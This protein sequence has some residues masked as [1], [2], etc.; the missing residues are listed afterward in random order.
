MSDAA[1]ARKT[2]PMRVLILWNRHHETASV[3]SPNSPATELSRAP[4]AAPSVPSS[5]EP[6]GRPGANAPAAAPPAARPSAQT[7]MI[8]EVAEALRQ[9]DFAVAVVEV[10][11]D[12][13]RIADALVVERPALVYNVVD[14]F[15][16]D[17]TRHA[18]VAAYWD[19]LGVTF[20]GSEAICLATCQDRVRT[21]LLL[22]DA[23]V[24]VPAFVAIRDINAIPDT[25]ELC[26][27]LVVTQA[28]DDVYD[29]E[30]AERPIYS[31]SELVEHSAELV[32]EFDLP[33]LVEEYIEDR[34]IHAVVLGN[35]VLEV[36]PVV[37]SAERIA[38][39]DEGDGDGDSDSVARNADQAT[40]Q[41]GDEG[42]EGDESAGPAANGADH[43]AAAMAGVSA[44]EAS[45]GQ[46]QGEP[47]GGAAAVW[48]PA[49]LDYAALDRVRAL[50]RRAFRA[51]GCRDVAQ[52][53]F[54]LDSQG[55]PFVV[56]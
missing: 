55:R 33:F 37:E 54:H 23:D 56:D 39:A 6:P 3:E 12:L 52:I 9:A 22:R 27:P 53:D 45:E 25:G 26:F 36:L 42:D 46:V 44:G 17:N 14:E 18:A 28:F 15:E 13:Q 51:M 47:G 5:A 41:P 40:G 11:D 7:T 48:V 2:E 29:E 19:L 35:R 21:H 49:Q 4:A 31:R 30:G 8:D 32:K 1:P 34:R 43:P 38:W 50:A 24:A 20:T 16:G 10:E